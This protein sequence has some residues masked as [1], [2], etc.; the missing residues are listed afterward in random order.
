V[1]LSYAVIEIE[2]REQ[3]AD[4]SMKAAVTAGWN[5]K[6]NKAV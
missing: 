5:V 6:E 3:N 2:A 1:A 4:G